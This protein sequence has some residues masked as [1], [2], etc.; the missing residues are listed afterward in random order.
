MSQTLDA[1]NSLSKVEHFQ[2]LSVQG[3]WAN[4]TEGYRR[5]ILDYEVIHT[6]N[7]NYNKT[8]VFTCHF[9]SWPAFFFFFTLILK[10]HPRNY[11]LGAFL[12]LVLSYADAVLLEK[13]RS[14][15]WDLFKKK[16]SPH[17]H[18]INMQT[19]CQLDLQMKYVC[20]SKKEKKKDWLLLGRLKNVFLLGPEIDSNGCDSHWAV[21]PDGT[22][23]LR[24]LSC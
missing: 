18:I 4:F 16:K 15:H 10:W 22:Y 3:W 6:F 14:I 11:F 9:L 12:Q 5:Q 13:N 1:T 24:P 17:P 19:S 20:C 8:P 7:E 21:V 2:E 23:C